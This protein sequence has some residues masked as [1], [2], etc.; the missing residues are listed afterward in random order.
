VF[1]VTPNANRPDDGKTTITFNYRATKTTATNT[2]ENFSVPTSVILYNDFGLP[3]KLGAALTANRDPNNY[4]GGA[5]G[6][7]WQNY[8]DA[9]NNAV[10]VV[11]RPKLTSN[12]MT[13]QVPGFEPAAE[14]LDNAVA[15][16]EATALPTGIEAVK[17]ALDAVQ[18]PNDGLAFDDDAYA[19]FGREDY[20][21]HTY[22][23]YARERDAARALWNAQFGGAESSVPATAT[24]VGICSAPL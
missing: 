23:R 14:G 21:P 1:D 7:E 3:G 22:A 24:A 12:F 19:Y 6:L 16:L 10:A 18:P 4:T 17:D 13:I 8:L 20:R 9:L 15:A 2:E 11:Y 5:A